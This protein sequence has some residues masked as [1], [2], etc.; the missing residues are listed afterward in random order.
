MSENILNNFLGLG[1]S[2]LPSLDGALQCNS[3]CLIFKITAKL[4]SMCQFCSASE[5]IS[6]VRPGFKHVKNN[7]K[8]LIILL[9]EF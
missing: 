2:I 5:V 8:I 7:L 9:T 4:S 1:K 3:N 6:K